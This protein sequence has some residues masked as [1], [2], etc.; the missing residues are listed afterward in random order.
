MQAP[1]SKTNDVTLF[2]NGIGHFRRVYNAPK[3]GEA[4]ISIPFKTDSIGDVAASLQV[5]GKVKLTAPPSF[6]PANSNATSL[7]IEQDEAMKSLLRQL[8]GSTVQLTLGSGS[9]EY[10]L[11][12]LDSETKVCDGNEVYTDYVVVMKDGSVYRYPL[13]NVQNIEFKDEAV[14]TEIEKALKT[15]FQ[16]IKP[17]STLLDLTLESLEG[18]EEFSVQ[19]TIPVAAWKMR[20]AIR[21]DKGNF[22][23]E[24]AAI[25]DNNT[26]E[27]WDNF[28]VSV[29]TGNPISFSTDIA[30][31][32]VPKRRF[33]HLV[34]QTTLGNVDVEEA[35]GGGAVACGFE[36]MAAPP[37]A[38]MRMAAARGLG[39]KASVSNYA[40]FGLETCDAEDLGYAGTAAQSPGV[41]SKEVG[42]FCIF[43]SK[44]RITILAR[45]SAVVPMFSVPLQHAGVVL[46]YKEENHATRPYRAVK[47]KNETDYS[48]G[49]GK[50]V[51]YNEGI[52]SGECVLESTKP[53]DNRMLPHC[54]ENGM[55][56]SKKTLPTE[57]RLTAVRISDGVGLT[58]IVSTGVTE[59][60]LTNKKNEPFKLAL[61]HLS[62]LGGENVMVDFEGVELQEQEKLSQSNGW[63]AYFTV[64]ANQSATLKVTETRLDRREVNIVN[65]FRWVQQNVIES[66][67]S[68]ANDKTVKQCVEIQSQIDDKNRQIQE[69]QQRVAEVNQEREGVREDLRAAESVA[70]GDKLTSW[71]AEIDAA[72]AEARKLQKETIPNLT[73]ERDAL[74]KSLQETLS[75]LAV[76]WSD[77]KKTPKEVISE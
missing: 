77:Q 13:N 25:I 31:V 1:T 6:T 39:V 34:E 58:E 37:E 36:A 72:K 63:R 10:Q 56:V 68:I 48:L 30:N 28:R 11:L 4:A 50:T 67:K 3:D 54:L 45:K 20:Y 17:D 7:A 16:K 29:V 73:K 53:G 18:A 5:F 75:T 70:S 32:V 61:E 40:S 66:G 55:K 42:D 8:S 23:L 12:G 74:L 71:V 19:Y 15:N 69:A 64:G 62:I 47:F 59:Y 21:E 44:E 35:Y 41:D 2:S 65:H 76:S 57:S 22:T 27:D 24:G 43:T 9:N 60:T 33:V 14:R 46:L 52:F 38:K 49:K 51:I 26:D